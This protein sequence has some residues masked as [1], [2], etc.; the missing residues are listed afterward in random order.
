MTIFGIYLLLRMFERSEVSWSLNEKRINLEEELHNVTLTKFDD[1]EV[2]VQIS[3]DTSQT[4]EHEIPEFTGNLHNYFNIIA[5]QN[6]REGDGEVLSKDLQFRPCDSYWDDY[7]KH[8]EKQREAMEAISLDTSCASLTG[9]Y[10]SG[11]PVT[12]NYSQ[13]LI[14][15]TR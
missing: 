10:L 11:S 14:V 5:S 9:Y 8:F 15:I 6:Y 1:I 12:F 7:T 2:F 3:L 13:I 4:P